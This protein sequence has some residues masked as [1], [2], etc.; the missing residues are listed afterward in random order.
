MHFGRD[1]APELHKP[2]G[3]H[4][5][6]DPNAR[7]NFGS[8][9]GGAAVETLGSK[10]AGTGAIHDYSAGQCIW[11]HDRLDPSYHLACLAIERTEHGGDG[12]MRSLKFLRAT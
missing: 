3:R 12:Q 10:V 7:A 6:S 11:R 1:Q 2:A 8:F 4:R 9:E 5:R